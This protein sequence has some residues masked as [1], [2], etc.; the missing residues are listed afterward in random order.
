MIKDTLRTLLNI[1]VERSRIALGPKPAAGSRI[2]L[3]NIRMF[4]TAEPA[5]DLWYFF[6]LQGWRE[7]NYPRDRR[8]YVDLPRAS[9][10]LLSRCAKADR[11]IRYRQ[12]VAGVSRVRSQAMARR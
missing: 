9:F 7:L 4:V 3:G 11:E 8:R 1:R 6:S 2:A 5:D 12:L 10:G